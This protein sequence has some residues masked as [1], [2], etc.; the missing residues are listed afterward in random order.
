LRE[1][2]M[3]IISVCIHAVPHGYNKANA[4]STDDVKYAEENPL[5]RTQERTTREHHR[6]WEQDELFNSE[7][8]FHCRF[9]GRQS[10]VTIAA[11]RR[12]QK[13]RG[14]RFSN[15]ERGSTRLAGGFCLG[16]R[17]WG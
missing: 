14:K 1:E 12:G 10:Q 3:Y 9:A 7:G 17:L 4:Q 8:G 11:G 16:R 5:P 15:E 2:G 6:R 13:A